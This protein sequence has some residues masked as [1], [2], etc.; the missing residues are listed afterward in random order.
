MALTISTQ[1]DHVHLLNTVSTALSKSTSVFALGGSIDLNANSSDNQ[2]S[3]VI[4]WDSG[5]W[6]TGRKVSFPLA[7]DA[8]SS[9]AFEKLLNDSQRATFGAGSEEVLDDDYRKAGK[10][11][12]T[13][14]CTDFNIAEHEIINTV[15]QVLVHAG[16]KYGGSGVS[17]ELD[18]LNVS[19][20][21]NWT[22]PTLISG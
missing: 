17:A 11:D 2:G 12:A 13:Q 8:A 10:M 20:P 1:S 3:I 15:A 6:N 7:G 19:S 22:K 9:L 14:F 16:E 21:P 5:E 18:K 4:R